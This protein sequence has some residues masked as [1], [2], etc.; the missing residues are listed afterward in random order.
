[1]NSIIIARNITVPSSEEEFI[2][3]NLEPYTRYQIVVSAL[4]MEGE[5][6][7]TSII[8]STVEAGMLLI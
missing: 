1:M 6:E 7:S 3:R 4:N 5:G 2:V 8:Q